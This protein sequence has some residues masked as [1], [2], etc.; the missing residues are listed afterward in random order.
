AKT[1]TEFYGVLRQ[2]LGE[3]H[4]SHFNI[5]PPEAIVQDDSPEPKDGGI[6]IDLRLVDDQPVITRVEQGSSGATAGL[7]TGFV[8]K[9]I[10]DTEVQKVIESFAK[11]PDSRS[12]TTLKITRALLA[13]VNGLPETTV[14]VNYLDDRDQVR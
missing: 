1:D 9:R 2:M 7:R 10:D 12:I 5:I 4:Q 13:R 6:G 14:R 3:L 8:I 11:S